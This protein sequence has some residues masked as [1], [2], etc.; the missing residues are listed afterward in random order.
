MKSALIVFIIFVSFSQ[1]V[2]SATD[3]R[4][5]LSVENVDT[6]A[7]QNSVILFAETDQPGSEFVLDQH[8]I[9]LMIG[10]SLLIVLASLAGGWLP[11]VITLTHTRMQ[12]M[13]S[14]I[15]GL[16]LGI[17]IFHMLPHAVK[18]LGSVDRCVWWMMMGILLMFF[19]M[20]A[21]HFHDHGV[22]EVGEQPEAGE[23][24]GDHNH[25]SHTHS[26]SHSHGDGKTHKLSWLGIAVGLGVHTLID[27]IALAAS[28]HSDAGHGAILSLFGLGTFLAIVLHKPLDAVSITSLMAASGWSAGWRNAVNAF[29]ASMCPLG[30]VLFYLGLSRVSSNQS[31]IVG[32]ALAFSAG[33]FLCIALSDLLP[34]MELHSHN[35]I[36]LTVAL[37]IGVFIA[38]LISFLEPD[39]GHSHRPNTKSSTVLHS[40]HSHFLQCPR[41][42][43]SVI[44]PIPRARLCV[45][46][47]N[48]TS[49]RQ[50]TPPQST[51][52]KCGCPPSLG[53]LGDFRSNRQT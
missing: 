34:E 4:G 36:P 44:V 21:F 49:L 37:L 48:S 41:S 5:V 6:S 43:I 51:Q 47:L 15:G 9:Q 20:R 53:S 8:S 14:L 42:R 38:W 7:I 27:G 28:V 52:T 35:R 46:L 45:R 50:V 16:M 33:V 32:C 23:C 29:F 26:H 10:Y 25:E 2:C 3:E 1:T 31:E 24:S 39:H 30:A 13:M 40:D 22:A 12:L 17:G 18:E 11:S 19:L